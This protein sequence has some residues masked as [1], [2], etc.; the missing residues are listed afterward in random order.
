MRDKGGGVTHGCDYWIITRWVGIHFNQNTDSLTNGK[1]NPVGGVWF[2]VHSICFDDCQ[3]MFLDPKVKEGK[4]ANVND[5]KP[6][7]RAWYHTSRSV[8]F[9]PD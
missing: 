6:N 3:Q 8:L 9:V 2:D 1:A 5:V 7:C 4:C